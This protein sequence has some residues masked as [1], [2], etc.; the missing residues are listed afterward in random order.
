MGTGIQGSG[1]VL[2]VNN[3]LVMINWFCSTGGRGCG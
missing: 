3:A 1:G 2:S